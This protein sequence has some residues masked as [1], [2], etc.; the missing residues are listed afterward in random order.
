MLE[1]SRKVRESP[2]IGTYAALRGGGID[3]ILY[4]TLR[5]FLWSTKVAPIRY[6]HFLDDA[7]ERLLL[8]KVGGSYKFIHNQLLEYFASLRE[9]T[10]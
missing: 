7:S 6:A 9:K 4:V 10:P 5:I 1:L 3:C 2:V 8:Q